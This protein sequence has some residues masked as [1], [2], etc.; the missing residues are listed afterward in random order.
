M[1]FKEKIENLSY[2][3]NMAGVW[4][5]GS[6]WRKNM[7]KLI[8]EDMPAKSDYSPKLYTRDKLGNLNRNQIPPNDFNEI[9]REIDGIVKE[10][11]AEQKE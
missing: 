6:Q 5:G 7:R 8:R 11:W 1:P 10:I 3:Q 9:T 4:G 2:E